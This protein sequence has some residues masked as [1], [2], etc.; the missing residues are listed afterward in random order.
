MGNIAARAARHGMRQVGKLVS[1]VGGYVV[2]PIDHRAVISDPPSDF[3]YSFSRRAIERELEDAETLIE[4][5]Q[6]EE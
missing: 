6:A 1:R 3:V 2:V 4:L 5:G